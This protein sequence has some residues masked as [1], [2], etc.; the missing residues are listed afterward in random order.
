LTY[1]ELKQAEKMLAELGG[2]VDPATGVHP[3][4][5][6]ID[7]EN[8]DAHKDILITVQEKKAKRASAKPQ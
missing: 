8:D 1:P 4:I 5:T 2:V 7:S 3:T 6:V